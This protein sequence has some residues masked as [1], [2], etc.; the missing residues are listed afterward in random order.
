MVV[1]SAYIQQLDE[2]EIHVGRL[3]D[4][5]VASVLA[6]GLAIE[7]GDFGVAQGVIQGHSATERLAREVED[8][9]MNMML[10][11]QPIAKDL[12]LVTS[13]FRLVSDLA[14]IAEMSQDIAEIV[15][16]LDPTTYNMLASDFKAMAA[17][18]ADMLKRACKAFQNNDATIAASIYKADDVVD[19]LFIKTRQQVVEQIRR[20]DELLPAAPELLMV[21]KY[22][23]RIGDHVC[24]IADWAAFRATGDYTGHLRA[25]EN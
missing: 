16:E 21:A 7:H 20:D 4:A 22:F 24:H 18:D 23:E 17:A 25:Q 8:S 5:V 13:A 12:R 15:M 3:G 19:K 2:L 10:L 11:Q 1:R 6:C 14:R 9:C